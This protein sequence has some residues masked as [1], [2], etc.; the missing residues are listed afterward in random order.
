MLCH[1]LSIPQ[2]SLE[3]LNMRGPTRYALLP[4]TAALFFVA[5]CNEVPIEGLEKSLQ[6]EVEKSSGEEA[7]KIDFLWV[8]DNSTSMCEEQIQLAENFEQF[9]AT[10]S[11][12]FKL[13]PRL[14][15]VSHDMSCTLESHG[16][17]NAQGNFSTVP[18]TGYPKSCQPKVIQQCSQDSDCGGLDAYLGSTT[19][20]G[21]WT[22]Q[23]AQSEFCELNPNGSYNT[24]CHRRCLTDAECQTVFGDPRYTCQIAGSQDDWSCLLPPKTDGC[25]DSLGPVLTADELPQFPCLA[26]I[27]VNQNK[28][29]KYEQ[30]LASA[31]ASL[32]RSGSNKSYLTSDSGSPDFLREDAYLVILF[33]TD[34]DDCS[35]A[36]GSPGDA[37]SKCPHSLCGKKKDEN[38]DW[39]CKGALIEDVY[40]TCALLG[41]QTEGG[42]LVPVTHYT[43]QIKSLKA[44][45]SK[46]IVAA[47]AGDAVV[48]DGPASMQEQFDTVFAGLTLGTNNCQKKCVDGEWSEPFGKCVPGNAIDCDI[49]VWSPP[50]EGATKGLCSPNEAGDIDTILSGTTSFPRCKD[51]IVS[52]SAEEQSGSVSACV[53]GQCSTAHDAQVQT[54]TEAELVDILDAEDGTVL[55]AD[56]EQPTQ[57]DEDLLTSL[58]FPD[59]CA[60]NCGDLGTCSYNACVDC[61]EKPGDGGIPCVP[62][63]AAELDTLNEAFRGVVREAYT[64]SKGSPYTCFET[65]YVCQ[66]DSGRADWGSR[67]FE[68]TR[69][70]GPS[71][72]FTNICDNA[73]IGPAL[74]TIAEKIINVVN[75]MCLPIHIYEYGKVCEYN[76]DCQSESCS[77]GICDHELEVLKVTRDGE[78]DVFTP[79]I[80]SD[81]GEDGTY[82]II[83]GGC[84]ETGPNGEDVFKDA[85]IFGSPPEP[86]QY[87]EINY[88]GQP[89]AQ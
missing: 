24:E 56:P 49:G 73:G 3:V 22:C 45:P 40:D 53:A 84:L 5:G 31:M 16:V 87:V 55:V 71:G 42:P 50:A 28:C 36:C 33:V 32:D 48:P 60:A 2:P 12:L 17:T 86:G 18:A 69:R 25:P 65:T 76:T 34:E 51:D 44:D 7:V 15:V 4:L 59:T 10:L 47:I 63:T 8:I 88:K 72:I 79:L 54:D 57:G 89:V 82:Q 19:T 85:I 75:R 9:T 80:E 6:I 38:G 39:R 61:D 43:N 70:F 21:E 74:K 26:T 37:A 1:L 67:Y 58:I 83:P 41:D 14:A 66:S 78:E 11:D 29:F 64:H 81:S 27:G 23:K 20:D 52:A 35:A 77:D 13:D 46:V 30:G 68:L 62:P